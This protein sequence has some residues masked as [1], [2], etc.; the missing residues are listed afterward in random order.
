[1]LG[2]KPANRKYILTAVTLIILIFILFI[3]PIKIPYSIRAYCRIQPAQKWVL[4]SG[5]S[6]QLST[7]V[8]NYKNGTSK[9]YNIL[10]FAREGAMHL[11]F[12]PAIDSGE[13]I[14]AGDT[15]ATIYSS[16]T[17]EN[18]ADL[19][20]QLLTLK[21]TLA[22]D[23]KGEK[24]SI[25]DEFELKLARAQEA[26]TNQRLIVSRQKALLE[27]NLISQQEYDI[28]ANKESLM[29]VEIGIAR[30][31]LESARTGVKAEQIDLIK[32]QIDALEQHLKAIRK[33][34]QTF[35]IISPIS[36]KI[37]RQYSPDTL[38]VIS[39]IT[40][41]VA[42]I[43]FKLREAAHLRPGLKVRVYA[44][45]SKHKISGR[46]TFVDRD[47]Y[48]LSG[49]QACVATA[50]IEDNGSDLTTGMFGNCIVR[51]EPV[52]IPEFIWDFFRNF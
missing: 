11:T 13:F 7:S 24:E 39:D 29:V 33:R 15:V 28:E 46:L 37:C 10:Q 42:L 5:A 52:S 16:E 27:K 12:D 2:N 8:I 21:A 47:V 36:G 48:A 35:S 38:L 49:E 18:L 9:G 14:N 17:E 45:G 32:T 23:S 3:I 4:T 31:Q 1:M 41:Y 34:E 43:P 30:S 26:E 22:V 20:G 19:N 25:V 50:I 44:D 6:G 51:C 40:S